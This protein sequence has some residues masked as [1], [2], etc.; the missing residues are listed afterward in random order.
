MSR[1]SCIQMGIWSKVSAYSSLRLHLLSLWYRPSSINIRLIVLLV[2]PY[3]HIV[4]PRGV[5]SLRPQMSIALSKHFACYLAVIQIPPYYRWWR[6]ISLSRINFMPL[7]S[8][9]LITNIIFSVCGTPLTLRLYILIIC[10]SPLYIWII[11]TVISGLTACYDYKDRLI[12]LL[13]IKHT[14][15]AAFGLYRSWN[16]QGQYVNYMQVLQYGSCI[17]RIQCFSGSR[18]S[19]RGLIRWWFVLPQLYCIMDRQRTPSRGPLSFFYSLLLLFLL[20]LEYLELLSLVS[21]PQSLLI[22]YRAFCSRVLC[23]Y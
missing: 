20:S 18:L 10:T 16:P 7:V 8:S 14:Y 17:V 2:V 1:S 9:K 22:L 3:C 12:A 11:I 5:A 21:I 6:F 13:I 15:M 4:A 23:F 19:S